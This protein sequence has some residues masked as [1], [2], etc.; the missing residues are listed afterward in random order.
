MQL[1]R[2]IVKLIRD[3]Y[4]LDEAKLVRTASIEE[5]LGLS[6]EKLEQILEYVSDA[7]E[8]K[9]PPGTLDELVRLEELCLLAS[10]MAGFYKRPPFV[11]DGYAAAAMA[12]N[13]RAKPE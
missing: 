1:F 3:E 5:D 4:G 6:Q 2:W 12:A 8:V 13:P 11:G 9:F 10:W 7:F